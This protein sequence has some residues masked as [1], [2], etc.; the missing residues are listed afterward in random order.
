MSNFFFT[1]K[2]WCNYFRSD[3]AQSSKDSATWI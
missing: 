2:R 1:Q 3:T